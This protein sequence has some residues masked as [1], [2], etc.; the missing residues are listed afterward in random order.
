MATTAESGSASGA[1]PAKQS[2]GYYVYGIV[3]GDVEVTPDAVGVGDPPA[4]V[5]VVRQGDVAALVSEID[6]S[7]PLGTP[8]DLRAHARLLDGAATTAP[9]L[10]LRFGAV[11]T[12]EEAVRQ[13][14]LAEHEQEFADAL[15]E[16]EGRVQFTV[17]ARYVEQAVL[18]EIV[19]E[20]PEIAQLREAIAQTPDADATRNERIQLGQL[21][22]E[23]I[24]Q[25]RRLDSN[26]LV[27]RLSPDSDSHVVR[28]PSHDED[29][30]HIA[31]LVQLDEQEAFQ[32][33]VS[34]IQQEWKERVDI[35]LLG[36]SA[37]YDF[38][39]APPSPASGG[40]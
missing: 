34:E 1:E 8:D 23:A 13:E 12:D 3:P 17:R 31:F 19:N 39:G 4:E 27:E 2:R 36:P 16:L 18:T 15:H 10:P 38:V 14:L 33:A 28:E 40:V 11:L 9:V 25:K 30:A 22:S 6:I 29:A 20:T 26:S 5:K 24:E 37:P 7:M 32:A 21:V 35:V